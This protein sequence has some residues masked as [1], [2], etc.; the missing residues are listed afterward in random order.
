MEENG[1]RRGVRRRDRAVADE[2]WMRRML[3]SAPVGVLSMV[4]GHR[5]VANVNLFALDRG[6]RVIYLHTARVGHARDVV[7]GNPLVCFTVARAG[8]VLP[9]DTAL[10]FSVEYASVVVY[11]MASVVEDAQE[12]HAA[13]QA[14]LDK[15]SPHLR[16]GRD[17]RHI[18][19]EEL[20]RTTVVRVDVDTWHGKEKR[21]DDDHAGSYPLKSQGWFGV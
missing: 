1:E 16:P 15:Y 8:R 3:A 13:L 20:R 9:A 7:S 5:P 4:D 12:A 10:E 14:L 6:G 11:G 19:P 21:V 17:Y 18:T 2:G